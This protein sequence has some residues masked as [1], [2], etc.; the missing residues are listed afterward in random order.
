MEGT[1][2]L[3]AQIN[4]GSSAT[5]WISKLKRRGKNFTYI[6]KRIKKST[7]EIEGKYNW[8]KA[9]M[10]VAPMLNT[11]APLKFK[12]LDLD[13]DTS[14]TKDQSY[15]NAITAYDDTW[16]KDGATKLTLST[17]FLTE[18]RIAKLLRRNVSPYLPSPVFCKVRT[19]FTSANHHNI[20]MEFAG[21]EL[22]SKA[23]NLSL[24]EFQSVIVQVLVALEWSQTIAHFKHHD[25]HCGNIYY[26]KIKTEAS[27]K[28]PNDTAVTLPCASVQAVIADFGL[29]VA[30]NKQ[31]VRY[32]RL[33]FK[34][35]NTDDKCW[36]AW[37]YDLEGNEGYD[38]IVLL[39]SLKDECKG[40]QLAWILKVIADIRKLLPKIRISKIGRPMCKVPLKPGDILKMDSFKF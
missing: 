19:Y 13:S 30:T 12:F 8:K 31:Q 9:G 18:C 34:L 35:L 25:L 1:L 11:K 3:M 4:K 24:L 20:I 29:S 36:G 17:N 38:F 26:K 2:T 6:A 27:W 39:A 16:K 14:P 22:E 10:L 37:D 15:I 28:L 23:E 7:N 21:E 40:E 5:I 32:G 33:D